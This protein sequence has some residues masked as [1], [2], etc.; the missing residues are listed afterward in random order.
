MSADILSKIDE[1]LAN[2]LS[3]EERER[4]LEEIEKDL[5]EPVR[6]IGVGQTGVGK[7]T[8]LKSVFSINED[9]PEI[10][11]WLE[12][13]GTKETTKEFRSFQIETK[14][15]FKVEFT[16]GPGLGASIERN[17]KVLPQWIEQ[18][19][20]HDMMYW[21]LDASSRDIAHIQRHMKK[22]LDETEYRN[23]IVVVLNKV[24]QIE[25]PPDQREA[26]EEQWNSKYNLP[27]DKL[28]NQIEKRTDDI[29]EKFSEQVDI[30][31]EQMVACSA[32][33]R[34]NNDK[35]LDKLVDQL[36]PEKRLKVL[37]SRDVK[38]FTDL[39]ADNVKEDF[40]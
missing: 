38:D 22:I 23:R 20:K 18:I 39:M 24:D 15:G 14:E 1:Q 11:D 8:L 25:L 27:T 37:A 9:D 2:E 10:P 4:L 36:P 17:E 26:G 29:I 6:I 33:K 12:E 40:K 34:W 5:A 31:R 16:D 28:E 21:V 30:S 7:S 35:F 32:L 13:G 19:P 3:E